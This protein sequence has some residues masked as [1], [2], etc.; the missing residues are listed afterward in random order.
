MICQSQN[1]MRLII[2]LHFTI[3]T[4]FLRVRYTIVILLSFVTNNA[5][6]VVMDTFL[7]AN[8]SKNKD[9]IES[10]ILEEMMSK[11]WCITSFL[12][13]FH[14]FKSLFSKVINYFRKASITTW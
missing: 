14:S 10:G 8:N 6:H 1:S 11:T 9:L 7:N 4:K 5:H 13:E 3:V 12:Q 2:K